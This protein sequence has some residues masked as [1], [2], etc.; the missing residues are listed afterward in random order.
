MTPEPEPIF[1]S[2]TLDRA[3]RIRVA[4]GGLILAIAFAAAPRVLAWLIERCP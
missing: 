3:E 2:A 1:D 4:I